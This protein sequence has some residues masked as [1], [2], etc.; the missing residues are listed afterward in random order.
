M[1]SVSSIRALDPLGAQFSMSSVLQHKLRANLFAEIE[2][3]WDR[4]TDGQIHALTHLLKEIRKGI[5]NMKKNVTLGS[6]VPKSAQGIDIGHPMAERAERTKRRQR[7]RIN[8]TKQNKI[9][10]NKKKST[11]KGRFLVLLL[12]RLVASCSNRTKINC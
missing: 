9:K 5:K 3:V 10:W 1:R 4:S 11:T 6:R 7:T 8:P 12:K 2:L